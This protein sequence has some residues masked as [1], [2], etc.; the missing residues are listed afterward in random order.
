MDGATSTVPYDTLLKILLIG[1]MGSNKRTLLQTYMGV[2]EFS[3]PTTLGI[4][5]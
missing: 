1:D 5:V 2:E 4:I 3:D